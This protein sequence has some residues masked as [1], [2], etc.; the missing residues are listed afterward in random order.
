MDENEFERKM[1]SARE[2]F[3]AMTSL[4]R[5]LDLMS[6]T[7]SAESL[8]TQ[9]ISSR[10]GSAPTPSETKISVQRLQA[11]GSAAVLEADKAGHLAR[12]YPFLYASVGDLRVEDVES[13]LND[14]KELVLKYYSL[15][16]AVENLTLTQLASMGRS[17]GGSVASGWEVSREALEVQVVSKDRMGRLKVPETE[18]SKEVTQNPASHMKVTDGD[19]MADKNVILVNEGSNSHDKFQEQIAS[20]TGSGDTEETN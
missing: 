7:Q 14:Y 2:S 9:S 1:L 3:N 12:E 10:N 11:S 13:L 16:K 15:H 19:E 18:D 4:P 5:A 17:K 20:T 8:D 6:E